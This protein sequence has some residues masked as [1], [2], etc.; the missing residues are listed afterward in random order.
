VD[1]PVAA[2]ARI[3]SHA[4]EAPVMLLPAADGR[5]AV[6]FAEPQPAVTPG[7]TVVLYDGDVVLAGGTIASRLDN[8]EP[9]AAADPSSLAVV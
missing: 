5:L 7:Q 2:Q 8:G 6:R 3:R 9:E 4:A 1:G